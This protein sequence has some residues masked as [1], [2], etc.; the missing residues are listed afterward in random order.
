[1]FEGLLGG[2]EHVHN[3]FGTFSLA[4]EGHSTKTRQDDQAQRVE[5]LDVF[6]NQTHF[7][8]HLKEDQKLSKKRHPTSCVETSK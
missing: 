6:T 1:M 4:P 7:C 8:P 2:N 5:S 3:K